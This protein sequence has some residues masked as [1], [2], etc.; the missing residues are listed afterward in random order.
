MQTLNDVLITWQPFFS[1][2]AGV[3]ATLAGLLFVSL[4]INRDKITARDNHNLLRIAK[5]S[6]GDYLY[7]LF[8]ALMFLMP[9]RHPVGL[10]PALFL[11]VAI[12]IGFLVYNVLPSRPIAGNRSASFDDLR[13]HAFQ[14]VS[15]LGLTIVG[16]EIYRDQFFAIFILVPVI[17]LLLYNASRNAWLLLVMEDAVEKTPSSVA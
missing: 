16:I 15:C 7:A 14:A 17:A 11:L 6:F 2:V 3:A 10:V 12:R 8:I 13:A 9:N 1:A 4:S 5:R